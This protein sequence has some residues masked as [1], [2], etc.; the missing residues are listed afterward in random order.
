MNN[1]VVKLPCVYARNSCSWDVAGCGDGEEINVR[2][3]V[4]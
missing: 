1:L 2:C 4:L 3:N